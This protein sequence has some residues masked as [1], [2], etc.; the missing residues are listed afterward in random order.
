MP[1]V[2]VS[3]RIKLNFKPRGWQ[4]QPV[5]QILPTACFSTAYK[6]RMLFVFLYSYFKSMEEIIPVLI[7]LDR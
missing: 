1:H 4:T 5:G 7:S 3:E 2:S 6:L